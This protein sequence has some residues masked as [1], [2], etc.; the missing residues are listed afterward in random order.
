MA[1]SGSVKVQKPAPDFKCTAVINGE[2]KGRKK[3]NHPKSFFF[4]SFLLFFY[5][6]LREL[7]LLTS[8]IFFSFFLFTELSLND[9]TSSKQWLILA[10]IPMAWTFVCPTEII[11]YSDAV[12]KFAERNARVVFASTDSEFS[13]LAWDSASRKDGGLGGVKIPLLSDK[14]M[15][16]SREYGVLLEEEGVALRGLFIIDGQGI[17]RQ[18]CSSDKS[19]GKIVILGVGI[20]D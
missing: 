5:I 3:P 9:F 11:A 14:N 10:F 20:S 15:R 4:F 19:W 12:D 7:H 17:V 1:S 13:L 2:F 8:Q 6:N 16:I 18:V